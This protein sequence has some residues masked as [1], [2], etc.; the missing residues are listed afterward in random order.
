[1]SKVMGYKE[2]LMSKSI[3]VISSCNTLLQ[4]DSAR[5]FCKIVSDLISLDQFEAIENYKYFDSIIKLKTKQI[6]DGGK[7]L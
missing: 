7:S 4:L 6:V 1:M 2:H 5:N 3:K